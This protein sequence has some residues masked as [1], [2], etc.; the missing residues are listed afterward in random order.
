MGG[1]EMGVGVGWGGR[2]PLGVIRG[3]QLLGRNFAPSVYV[4]LEIY[5]NYLLPTYSGGTGNES[6]LQ[7]FVIQKNGKR[8]AKTYLHVKGPNL[9]KH[10]G[11]F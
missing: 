10:M 11:I 7:I 4:K 3:I 8:K 1:G 9:A 2:K 5:V 6:Q